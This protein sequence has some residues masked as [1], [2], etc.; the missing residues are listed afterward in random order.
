MEGRHSADSGDRLSAVKGNTASLQHVFRWSMV[1]GGSLVFIQ[2][3]CGGD[4]YPRLPSGI[5]ALIK[6]IALSPPDPCVI[7]M[8][9]GAKGCF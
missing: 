3:G 9:P 7:V 5:T 6:V 4:A 1:G 8:C 2:V